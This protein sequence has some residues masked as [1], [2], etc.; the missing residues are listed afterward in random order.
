VRA[1]GFGCTQILNG[2][3]E[4]IMLH[5]EILGMGRADVTCDV[6]RSSNGTVGNTNKAVILLA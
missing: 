5:K 6:L 4:P 2:D 3:R 1:E